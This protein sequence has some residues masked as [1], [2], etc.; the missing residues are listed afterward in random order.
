MGLTRSD[1]ERPNLSDQDRIEIQAWIDRTSSNDKW[2]NNIFKKVGVLLTSHQANRPYLKAS[3]ESHKKLGFW[4]TVAYDSYIDP[5]QETVDHNHYMPHKDVLDQIDTF[6]ISHYQ[7]WGGPLYPYFW[8][9][10]LGAGVM[11]DFEYIYCANGDFVIEKPEG[12]AELFAMLGDADVMTSGPDRDKPPAAN[13]AGFLIRSEALHRVVQH[14][15]DHLIPW[16]VYEKYTQDIG[17]MEGRFGWAIR[18]LGLKQVR[19]EPPLEDMFRVPGHGTWWKTIGFR[20]IHSEMNYAYRNKGIPPELKYL[21][22]RFTA[23][24]DLH[25][26]KLWED[27]HDRQYLEQWWAAEP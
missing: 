27:T 1:L 18:D 5:V 10:K 25:F 14:M 12:F 23:A 19:V 22:E 17:N 26:L 21:D 15:Q 4:I 2:A 9:L 11:R 16:D 20:H 13:T 3:V 24:H 8:L 6:L 7:T